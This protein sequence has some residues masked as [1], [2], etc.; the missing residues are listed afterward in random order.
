MQTINNGAWFTARSIA[1]ETAQDERGLAIS[2]AYTVAEY[3]RNR[4]SR[5]LIGD[6]VRRQW[7][8]Q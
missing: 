8:S 5:V 7:L 4:L 3:D 1:V 6:F 2:S